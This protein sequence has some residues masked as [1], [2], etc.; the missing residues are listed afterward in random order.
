MALSVASVVSRLGGVAAPLLLVLAGL[1]ALPGT[2]PGAAVVDRWSATL[3]VKRLAMGARGCSNAADGANCSTSSV[4]TDDDFTF[5]SSTLTVRKLLV[6]SSGAS[7]GR[8]E[9]EFV[10]D[11]PSTAGLLY[12]SV[13]NTGF[14]SRYFEFK[15]ADSKTLSGRGWNNSGLS[16]T[17]GDRV[18]LRI[19]EQ[20]NTPSIGVPTISGT[21]RVGETLTAS[22]SD[23][24]DTDGLRNVLWRYQWMQVDG[25][26]ESEIM[27][28]TSNTYTLASADQGKK[29]KV[30]VLFQD[31]AGFPE[32]R[33]SVSFPS[34][35]TIQPPPPPPPPPPTPPL[36]PVSPKVTG[37]STTSVALQWQAPTG[38]GPLI[39]NYDVRYR[40]GSEGHWTD[41][42]QDV[43]GTVTTIEGLDPDTEYEVQVRSSG[44][45]EHSVWTSLERVRTLAP[46]PP[47]AEPGVTQTSPGSVTIEWTAPSNDN[48]PPITGYDLRYR[49]G[50]EGEWKDG[51][52]DVTDT[53]AIIE[54]LVPDTEYEVQIRSKSAAGDGDWTALGLVR[55]EVLVL[56]DLF[57]LSLDLDASEKDQNLWT[58]SVEPGRVVFIQI[59]GADIKGMRGVDLRV[60]FDTT[61]VG[62]EGFDAGDA[63]P[64]VT[65][66]VAKDSTFVDI[67][68]SS[69]V[70]AAAVDS[71]QVGTVRFRTKEEFTET[72][73]RMAGA[74]M[75]RGAH[76][77]TMTRSVS[78]LLHAPAPPSPDFDGNGMVDFADFVLFSGAFGYREGDDGYESGYDLNGDGQITLADFV[79]FA[80]RF[81]ERVNRSP[82]FAPRRPATLAVNGGASPG[83]PIGDP[84]TATDEDGDT[85][86]YSVWGA[87]AEHFGID[88]GS[89]QLL[90]KG[91][92]DVNRKRGY[93]V[94]VRADDGK[95]GSA[96]I[97]IL[98][99]IADSSG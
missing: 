52:R 22:T 66:L 17:V 41:G 55:T 3:T 81:G 16:W 20:S 94:I 67:D 7:A 72:E 70:G 85:L 91:A 12:L 59:F 9:L 8:L 14:A 36:P 40:E 54:G 24:V 30:R 92:Y 68:V 84:I 96:N 48:G 87:D 38:D 51:P 11:L 79:A 15:Y 62:F 97:V 58:T 69:L 56:Y 6:H 83:A 35:G 39:R 82:V 53:S 64:G 50:D 77:E 21:A 34:T 88:S 49:E 31:D 23:I 76:P 46:P 43:R 29:V 90:T 10:D 47:P 80:R 26:T 42:P 44:N 86:T 63:L 89:G 45:S 99:L 18:S 2:A 13:E 5:A 61:Q 95:G 25:T 65:S 37:L 98:I 75:V 32:A 28:A 4:L 33:T 71:G 73:V 60:G 78:V 1:A 57:S 27:G 74:D 19:V 93:S